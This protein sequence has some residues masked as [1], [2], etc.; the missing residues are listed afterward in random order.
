[1]IVM[2][3]YNSGT[4]HSIEQFWYSFAYPPRHSSL[5]RWCPG[6]W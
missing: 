3:V 6:I 5:L 1:M 4:Q 2:T